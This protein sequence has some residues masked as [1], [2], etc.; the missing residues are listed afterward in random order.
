MINIDN[1]ARALQTFRGRQPFDHCV[2]DDFFTEE[3]AARLEAEFPAYDSQQWYVYD[4]AI[5]H[6]RAL[7][8]WNQYPAATYQAL[9]F[10]VSDSFVRG[11]VADTLG[12]DIHPDPGLHGG[13]WHIHGSGGNLN[14]HMDY[15]LH[16][17]MGA[18]RK[19]NLIVYLSSS[20]EPETHGG[21]FG[22]WEHDVDRPRQ[23]MREV[24][25]Q[26]NRAVLFDTTQNSWHGMSR[27]LVV[28]EGVYRKSLAVYYMT[29]AT[30]SDLAAR[31]R[32]L[33]APRTD[34]IGDPHVAALIERRVHPSLYK[35]AYR[36]KDPGRD[37]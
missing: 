27:Q 2:V 33:F 17:K 30:P 35:D 19:L 13:G 3:W 29:S 24:A 8:D 18:V 23:L 5:E 37:H 34:Q 14:P 12:I 1:V 31:Q 26:F 21:H 6:K 20:L 10:L 28:P 22:L 36:N 25:P 32:A 15:H 11:T 9:T 7:N 16:P 4:N